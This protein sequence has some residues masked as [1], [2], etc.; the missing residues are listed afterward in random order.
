M[1]KKVIAII[2]A[3]PQFIK[4]FP[5]EMAASDHF[6]LMTIHT[7]QHYDEN[8]SQVFFD[9]LGM[10]T[11][12]FQL[13]LGGGSHGKQT[14]QML[15]EIENIVLKEE[16]DVIVVYGDTNSTLAG[17]LVASKLHIKLVHIEAGLRS[18]NKAMPE[19]VN[20]VLTDHVSDLLLVPSKTAVK[21]LKAEGIEKGVFMVG[22]IMKDLIRISRERDVLSSDQIGDYLYVTLHRPYNVDHEERLKYVLESLKQLGK[23]VIFSVHPRT[24][25]SI[26]AY[27]IPIGSNIKLIDPQ[28]YF[29]NLSLLSASDGLITDSGG[30]QKEAYWLEKPCITIRTETEWVE[31]LERGANQLLFEDLE[32]LNAL[33]SKKSKIVYDS[34]LYGDGYAADRIVGEIMNIL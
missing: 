32:K 12:D 11:P 23:Q 21:N 26:Q 33:I 28:P 34:N 6:N 20:R 16:P 27:H 30:M 3:R 8:M 31:T 5:L 17:A 13:S 15:I 1:N 19:E 25:Q 24:R 22:D 9:Q 7:G 10:K 18:Y 14:G 4:H 29:N 2:G